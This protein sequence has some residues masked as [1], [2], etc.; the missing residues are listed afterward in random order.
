ML[1]HPTLQ[2]IATIGA[3]AL[4][5]IVFIALALL[6]LWLSLALLRRIR[7]ELAQSGVTPQQVDGALESLTNVPAL[8]RPLVDEP[9]DLAILLLASAI[10]RDPVTVV[11]H[12][13]ATLRALAKLTTLLP[14]L[15][16]ALGPYAQTA[17]PA[18]EDR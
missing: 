6:L 9:T 4:L 1:D 12:L 11:N 5:V 3:G 7:V 18:E 13:D 8:L 14:E 2:T 10:R 16:N 17:K 15:R